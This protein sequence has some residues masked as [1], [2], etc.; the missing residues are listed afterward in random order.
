[1]FYRWCYIRAATVAVVPNKIICCM[2][3]W[4]T[5]YILFL[6]P[7]TLSLAAQ[8]TPDAIYKEGIHT[9][10]FHTYG[11][12][13]GMAVY[14]LK[15]DDR[16]EL[17]FDDLSSAVK[18]YYYTYQLC[19]YDW[20]PVNISPFDYIKG[21]TQQRITN[22]R[23][24]SVAFTRYIHYQATLPD[25]NSVPSRSGNYLLKVFLD[26][27]TSKLVFTRALL[28]LDTKSSVVAQVVQ[29]F[30]PQFFRTHQ[31]LK[32]SVNIE[33]LN[34]F[35]ANQQ[36]KVK[37]LQNYRWDNA[38][39]NLPP[40]FI[41]GNMLEYNNENSFVFPGGKEW[42]WL[43]LR[44]FRLLSDRIDRADNKKNS[45]SLYVKPDIDLSTQK[46]LF[47]PD[48][49]GQYQVMT[50]E[51]LNPYW[52]GDY[53]T[54]HFTFISPTQEEY[55]DKE[56]YIMGQQT[57]YST[58]QPCKMVF[59]P[60][61]GWYEGSQFL[62]Q[63]YYTYGYKL[64]DPKSPSNVNELTG[65]YWETENTYTIL[66][67]YRSF[68]DQADQLIGTAKISTRIDRPGFSF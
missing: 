21:F 59:N 8:T 34:A 39:N 11:D 41:R 62:K 7:F 16:L 9:V 18:S 10:R 53:A 51:T 33:G 60:E 32:F 47:Y 1:M 57:G 49:N 15:S 27:D 36:V 37:V 31:R 12:Q 42:R 38:K 13:E 55:K 14:R 48:L 58:E 23:Y 28:V 56:L 6:L 50:Y 3:L 45:F 20:Q 67:Y 22:Y 64:I 46:Y 52:Q 24:S 25:A 2:Q 5:L 40:T 26:G 29:P 43:D 30:T 4:R 61:K 17:H 65:D 44:S 68:T 19:D 66:V 63:G 54:V 35:N